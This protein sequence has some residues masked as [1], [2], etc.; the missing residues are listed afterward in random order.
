M[1]KTAISL[2]M[3]LLLCLELFAPALAAEGGGYI[4]LPDAEM[5]EIVRKLVSDCLLEGFFSP[6]S[7]SVTCS[8]SFSYSTEEA[9]R[10]ARQDFD[11]TLR[12]GEFAAWGRILPFD[13]DELLRIEGSGHMPGHHWTQ[14]YAGSYKSGTGGYDSWGKT[15]YLIECTVTCLR[16]EGDYI[17][18]LRQLAEEV[19]SAS[20]TAAGQL[21]YVNDWLIRDFS[22][23]YRAANYGYYSDS[24]A[25]FLET[26]T[27]VC[28][29]YAGT[30]NYLCFFLGIPCIELITYPSGVSWSTV[31]SH[32]WN[33][34]YVDGAW[35]M[36][37]VTW[38]DT[39]GAPRKY[40][41]VDSIDDNIHDWA[42]YDDPEIVA[43]AK[44]LALEL[45][46]RLAGGAAEEAPTPAPVTPPEIGVT[47]AGVPVAWTDA[48]PFIDGNS[49]TMVPLRA[50]GDALGLTVDW[51]GQAREASFSD[52]T[53]T[54]FF[55]IGSTEARTGGGATVPMDTAAV[56][57]GDRTYAPVRYLAEYFGHTVGWDGATRTVL[58]D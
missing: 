11:N 17:D 51:D 48:V 42:Q 5:E 15:D 16:S 43:L 14:G 35:K 4:D 24:V 31:Y 19:R 55:P 32:G 33:L 21:A 57:V 30:V 46:A 37:D 6:D 27:G 1:K 12:T 41:L 20:D 2:L 56:I 22:Y 26:G 34:V 52:G 9:Y 40:F 39:E 29:G 8:V 45:Q 54:I 18:R 13:Y 44:D 36:L 28:G 58:I 47:V 25:A 10:S 53:R 23:D 3:A 49:R 38:N 50:V 7:R